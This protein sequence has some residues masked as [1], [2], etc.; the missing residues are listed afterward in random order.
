[1]LH[2]KFQ[3]DFWLENIVSNDCLED[4]CKRDDTIKIYF[5]EMDYGCMK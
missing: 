2:Q 1:M 4:R 5:R 3:E